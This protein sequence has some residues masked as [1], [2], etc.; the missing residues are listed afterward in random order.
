MASTR[1]GYLAAIGES[2]VATAVKPTNFLRFEEGDIQLKQDIITNGPIQNNRWLALQAVPGKIASSGTYKIDADPN[3]SVWWLH[4]A[5]GTKVTADISSLTDASVFSHTLTVANT[6]PSL[7]IEQAKGN[8]SD[9][10]NSKQNYSVERAYGVLVNT[11]KLSA[12]DGIVDLSVDLKAH[13]VFLRARAI[14]NEDAESVST[15]ITAATWT[16]GVATITSNTHLLAAGDLVVIAAVDPAGYNGAYRV[17]SI[18]SADTFTVA[19]ASDPGAYSTGGTVTKQ[20]QIAV[21]SVDGLAVGD[22][23]NVVELTTP[24]AETATITVIDTVGKQV[25]FASLTSTNFT[26][27][28]ETKIEL[29][30]QS[31]SYS[32]AA[33]I[34]SFTHCSFQFGSTLALAAS[35]EEENIEKWEIMY[36]NNLEER[37]GSLR[38]SPSVIAPKGAKATLKYTKYFESVV[39]RDR[40]L[41]QTKRAG[42]LTI[43]NNEVVSATDTNLAKYTITVNMNDLRFTSYDMPT[44]T[45]E[46]YA[47]SVEA[48]AFY[49]TSDGSAFSIVVKN[50][51][52]ATYY[53]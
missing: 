34:F 27:A 35:A 41:N 16:G 9:T 36:E 3:E 40:Y 43:T 14:G 4:R 8:L 42:I 48:T 10:G 23:V 26:L 51:K 33:K 12:T 11:F 24:T 18:P 17:I 21:D 37:Y 32:T 2:I 47:V 20:S 53:A 13:G 28:N 46:L 30:P 1:L 25:G 39:D 29:I 22:S 38:A 6:L 19:I 5:L 49:D 45:D 7:T 31:P 50:A 15:N 52:A 44:G